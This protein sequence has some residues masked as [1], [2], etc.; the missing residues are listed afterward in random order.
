MLA[1][2]SMLKPT[3]GSGVSDVHSAGRGRIL[4]LGWGNIFSESLDGGETWREETPFGRKS[5]ARVGV[6][7]EDNPLVGTD[8]GA[9][10]ERTAEG[11]TETPIKGLSRVEAIASTSGATLVAGKMLLRRAAGGAEWVSAVPSIKKLHVALVAAAGDVLYASLCDPKGRA[12]LVRS[13]DHGATWTEQSAVLPAKVESLSAFGARAVAAVMG[14]AA[15]FT[16]DHGRQWAP[17]VLPEY[18]PYNQGFVAVTDRAIYSLLRGASLASLF[19]STDDGVTWERGESVSSASA[20]WT[21]SD[22]VHISSLSGFVLRVPA[23]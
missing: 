16:K 3:R 15:F 14:G 2:A 18:G 12:W 13:D 4:A 10:F 17:I 21:S 11:W 19:C 22:G 20:M 8:K 1:S 23:P 7:A 6:T 5:P 9:L